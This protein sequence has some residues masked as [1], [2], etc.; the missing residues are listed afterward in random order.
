MSKTK[1]SWQ[2]TELFIA[3]KLFIIILI[4]IKE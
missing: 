3:N 2:S 4:L 1:T